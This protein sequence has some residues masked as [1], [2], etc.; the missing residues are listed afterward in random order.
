MRSVDI[1]SLYDSLVTAYLC[2]QLTLSLDAGLLQFPRPA[3][4]RIYFLFV[5]F[6]RVFFSPLLVEA[7]AAGPAVLGLVS[8]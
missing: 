8:A 3:V 5:F 1:D 6:S 2:D 4:P 7:V